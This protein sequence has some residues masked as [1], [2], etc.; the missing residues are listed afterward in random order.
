MSK[1]QAQYDNEKAAYAAWL[2]SLKAG[3][4]VA[5]R[6]TTIG[7]PYF[8]LTIDRLT[9]TQGVLTANGRETRFIRT[10]GQVVGQ[11]FRSIEPV[12]P[13]IIEANRV[14][15][16]ATWAR[17]ECTMQISQLDTDA[18]QKVYDLVQSL[19]AEQK[20]KQS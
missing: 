12:T 6:C 14:A 13:E 9:D 18:K 5:C 8:V 1:T 16:L 19:L 7:I 15:E 17:Y 2:A 20:E 4:K 11:R 10:S 3:D